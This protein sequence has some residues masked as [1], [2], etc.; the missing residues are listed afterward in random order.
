MAYDISQPEAP[1]YRR[2][3]VG[4]A[5]A[6]TIAGDLLYVVDDFR[7]LRIYDL[8]VDPLSPPQLGI[9]T[10]PGNE[11]G[12]SGIAVEGN[13]AYATTRND[14]AFAIVDVSDPRSL[15]VVWSRS[16]FL[17]EDVDVSGGIACLAEEGALTIMDV[18]DPGN[19]QEL[20]R[21]RPH[22]SRPGSFSIG[23][24][25][26]VEMLG[27]RA[28]VLDVGEGLMVFDLTDPANPAHQGNY[29]SPRFLRVPQK[30]GDSL[31]VTDA[32]NGISIVNVSNAAALALRGAYQNSEAGGRWGPNWGVD[33][34]GGMAYLGAGLGG[35]EVVDVSDPATP[36]LAGAFLFDGSKA[37]AVKLS[38]IDSVGVMSAGPRIDNFDISDP[39]NI[40]RVGSV[41]L[42]GLHEKIYVIEVDPTGI[43]HA[44]VD[45]YIAV[46]DLSAAANPV[47]LSTL[48][49][50]SVGLPYQLVLRGDLRYV[51][52]PSREANGGGHYIHDI[53]DP[54]N[55]VTLAYFSAEAATGLAVENHKAFFTAGDPNNGFRTT[56]FALDV[57]TPE[58]PLL[59]AKSVLPEAG[60]AA[61]D[62][63]TVY[64]ST[65]STGLVAVRLAG[66]P[67][68]GDLN[69]DGQINAFDIE[70]FL[71]ALFD[72]ENYGIRYPDC[73]MN[74][75]DINGDGS[76]NAFDIEPFLR[77]LFGP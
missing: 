25:S 18:S 23:S 37:V 15:T 33:V 70:P 26:G 27:T 64:V 59:L 7:H 54:N 8:S 24:V 47:L 48:P 12:G 16:T 29:H 74:N 35:L 66:V 68:P 13:Y 71:V 32:F 14:G 62:G 19:M 42:P 69:C 36:T 9:V 45:G 50:P 67:F 58:S 21:I 39:A 77:L 1:V 51:T 63:D 22:G 55:P 53:G 43:A 38:L 4:N 40:R 46:V 5:R 57:S 28:Y 49:W 61:A 44:A 56:V 20:A 6:S 30:Q 76:I 11:D 60:F 65:I 72:P 3:A 73:D 52:N 17:A 31:Y 41:S 2:E 75:A 34:R 10:L